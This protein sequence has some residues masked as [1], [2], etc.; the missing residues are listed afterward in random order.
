MLGYDSHYLYV[1]TWNGVQ[2]MAWSWWFAYGDEAWALLSEQYALAP[3]LHTA[4]NYAELHA[5][6]STV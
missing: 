2:P 4:V 6:L 1:V 5:D 3:V